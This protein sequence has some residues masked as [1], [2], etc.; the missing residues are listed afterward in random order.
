VSMLCSVIYWIHLT[1]ATV[2]VH[3]LSHLP[4]LLSVTCFVLWDGG[5]H[6]VNWQIE[7]H[8]TF[9]RPGTTMRQTLEQFSKYK[10]Q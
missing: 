5:L 10:R 9:V 3:R 4:P 8:V 7:M 2:I 1:I 6:R